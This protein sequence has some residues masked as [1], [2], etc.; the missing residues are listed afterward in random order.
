MPHGRHPRR[1]GQAFLSGILVGISLAALG[2][3][4]TQ[5]FLGPIL[6]RSLATPEEQILSTVHQRLL[7][8]YVNP[9][10]SQEI[11]RAAVE[12]MIDSLDDRY[13]SFLGPEE[14]RAYKEDSSGKLIGIGVQIASNGRVHYPRPDGPAERAGLLPNDRIAAV[15]GIETQGLTPVQLSDLIKGPARS[16]VHLA[17]ER[18]GSD[19][20]EVDIVRT[21]MITG[22]V[23]RVDMID[24][25]LGIGRIHIRSFANSTAAEFDLALSKLLQ[26]DMKALVLDLRY[27]RGGLLNAAVDVAGRFLHGGVICTLEGRGQQRSVRKADPQ[28][29]RIADLP[30]VVLINELSAS[31]SEVLAGALRD[32]GAAVLVGQRSYGKGV[33]QQVQQYKEGDFVIKFTAGYYL[34]PGGRIIEGT[35]HPEFPGSLDPDL[36][37][38]LDDNYNFARLVVWLATDEPPERYRA[39]VY[40]LFEG[41]K[42]QNEAPVDPTM[43]RALSSLRLVLPS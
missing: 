12:G 21:P 24:S 29:T 36:P 11:M 34:T 28:D 9:P 15:D 42:T 8:D 4:L 39:Q 13:C 38:V 1:S 23:G 26:Q 35:I 22:T 32:R 14:V 31:G 2:V 27:N 16:N 5:A 7:N 10:D 20:F 25:E 33:Y 18:P 40:Q 6:A 41:L 30:V 3:V 19:N 37:V 17:V 43:D